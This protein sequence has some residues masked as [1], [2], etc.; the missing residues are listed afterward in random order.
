MGNS[1]NSIWGY[2]FSLLVLGFLVLWTEIDPHSLGAL[3][4]EDGPIENLSAM[5]L[6]VASIGF[7]LAMIRSEYL[8]KEGTY[9]AYFMTGAWCLLMFVFAGEEISWGQRIFEFSTPDSLAKINVQNEFN[10][11]N[12]DIVEKF[13]GGQY[14]YLSI[15][16]LLTGIVFPALV[17]ISWFKGLFA[18]FYFPVAPMHFCL[19]FVGAYIYGKLYVEWIPRFADLGVTEIREFIFSIATMCFALQGM[20]N[21]LDIII[22]RSTPNPPPLH[23]NATPDHQGQ[24]SAA[25]ERA[26]G[27]GKASGEPGRPQPHAAG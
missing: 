4:D 18:K 11:H 25:D 14:R 8:K 23:D 10:F 21:P 3:T 6:L 15:M 24:R 19:L 5:F 7:L 16:M 9:L 20:R 2:V 1:R 17:H 27:D 26:D 22:S 12:I 13:M